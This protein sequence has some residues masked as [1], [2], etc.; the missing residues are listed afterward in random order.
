[1]MITCDNDSK[2]AMSSTSCDAKCEHNAVRNLNPSEILR[3]VGTTK[4]RPR[5]GPSAERWKMGHSLRWACVCAATLFACAKR[6]LEDEDMKIGE[7]GI[8]ELRKRCMVWI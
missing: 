1:M 5:A 2:G 8:G 6:W 7:G 3:V 4:A